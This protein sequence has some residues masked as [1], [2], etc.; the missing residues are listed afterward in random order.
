MGKGLFLSYT[1][2]INCRIGPIVGIIVGMG[3]DEMENVSGF[4]VIQ[5][6]WYNLGG[7]FPRPI[8]N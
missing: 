6:L 8:K 2:K 1:T 3:G 4:F 5:I 7:A